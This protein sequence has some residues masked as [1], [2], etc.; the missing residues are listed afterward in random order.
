ML[1]T[2]SMI[3]CSSV[4]AQTIGNGQS[5]MVN[6]QDEPTPV[7]G[8]LLTSKIRLL[9]RAY[10]DRVA[11]RW[12]PEDYVS[13]MFL[14][15]SG[16]N[17]LRVDAETYQVDTIA[18]QLKPLTQQQFT[19]KYP[20]SDSLAMVA[21][22]V[23]YGEGKLGENQTRE[24]PGSQGANVE[25]N[26]DQDLS[27]A[28]AMLVAEWRPD[29][30]EAMAVGITDRTA[31]R[32]RRYDYYVQ[33]STH[34]FGGKIIFEP[35]VSEGV[36]NTA[37]KPEPYD[38]KLQYEQVSPRRVGVSWI[39]THH[40]SF[41]IER[42]FV[43]AF[44]KEAGRSEGAWQRLND[45]PYLSMVQDV[46]IDGLCIYSDSVDAEGTWEY[47]VLGHDAFGELTE[48]S[49]ALTAQIRDIEAPH[50]PQL[51]YIVIER[52]GEDPMARVLAH[53]VWQTSE[54][55]EKDLQGYLLHYYNERITGHRWMPLG[56]ALI[57]PTDTMA[58][59]DMTGLRTGMLSVFAY[60][61][62][63]NIGQS[64]PQLIR[65]TD[66]KA[67]AAP[68]SLRALTLPDG[69]VILSWQPKPEDNDIA[70]YDVA[71]ANDSTHEFLTL[72]QG[73]IKVPMYVDTL[74]LDV[75][76]KYVYYKVRAVDTENNFGEWTPILQVLRPHD[77]PPS[78]PHLDESWHN[79]EQGMHMR[80]IVGTD[81]D[82]TYHELLRRLGSKGEWEVLA[83]WDADSIA[84]T[85]DYAVTVDDNPP[86]DQEQRYYYM[87]SSHNSTEYVSSSLAVSWLHQGPHFLDIPISLSGAWV[88]HEGTVRL[89]WETG[90]IPQTGVGYYYCV[91]RKGEGDKRF[92]YMFNVSA[93]TPEYSD[94]TLRPGEQ[95]DY[96]V[97][98][99]FKDGRE[100]Q[101]SN[102]IT[103]RRER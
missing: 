83:V 7:Q 98:I 80:W 30:A 38:P 42:R 53:V 29:L 28:Y 50:A 99:R 1:L 24:K 74:G 15:H 84:A 12:L 88:E 5:S 46:D 72:N 19:A 96:Y 51:K 60:D 68:D 2:M 6:G 56:D 73:G 62:S 58:T 47:R 27:F 10:G 63:G 45:Q 103:V 82:M 90:A 85:G 71:F 41:E 52:P 69:Y 18:M 11:L 49:P 86:Y 31:R 76:Q 33:P 23:L 97:S 93:D 40:S 25:L 81:A 79:D 87:V 78:A 34:D 100:S 77:T 66:Y 21:V 92:K 61:D 75:N 94:Q 89:T 3:A 4:Y 91:F 70:Y 8:R 35:G 20:Q 26:N 54:P 43:R 16:V 95:A 37:Y 59:V 17:V 101:N 9:T 32:G 102:T 36:V 44:G 57:A 14:C 39:D 48:P 67:P 64:L 55:L 22:G 13:W 65:L